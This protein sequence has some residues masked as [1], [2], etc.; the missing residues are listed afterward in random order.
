[1]EGAG[2]DCI[3]DF[4]AFVIGI[5]EFKGVRKKAKV[6]GRRLKYA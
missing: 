1:L 2:D 3:F 6:A 5:S 4:D